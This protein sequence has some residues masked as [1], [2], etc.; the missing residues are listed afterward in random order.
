MWNA[1]QATK[2]DR[3]R[4]MAT[5]GTAD[6]PHMMLI[7]G[8]GAGLSGALSGVRVALVPGSISGL[9]SMSINLHLMCH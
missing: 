9:R 1:V 6:D 5:T 2:A 3:T 4:G 7:T 8:D